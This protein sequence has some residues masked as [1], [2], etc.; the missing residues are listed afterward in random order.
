VFANVAALEVSVRAKYAPASL[1]AIV[2]PE[3]IAEAEPDVLPVEAASGAEVISALI[4]IV[5]AAIAAEGRYT[6]TGT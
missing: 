3:R 5:S 4:V 1:P 6:V 2:P